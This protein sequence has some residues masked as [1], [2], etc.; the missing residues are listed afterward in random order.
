VTVEDN[1]VGIRIFH[2]RGQVNIA[3][4]YRGLC[5][6]CLKGRN[7]RLVPACFIQPPTGAKHNHKGWPAQTVAR[8]MP[9]YLGCLVKQDTEFFVGQWRIITIEAL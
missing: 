2:R 6:S 4:A 8:R 9:S 1:N 5:H 7:L 3:A